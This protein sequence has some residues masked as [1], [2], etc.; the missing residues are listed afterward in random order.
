VL[1]L[2]H[3]LAGASRAE[4][5]DLLRGQA[6]PRPPP[7]LAGAP[8]RSA[9]LGLRRE[10]IPGATFLAAHGHS[11]PAAELA[12]MLRALEAGGQATPPSLPISR[13]RAGRRA[14]RRSARIT[15]GAVPCSTVARG[16]APRGITLIFPRR[17]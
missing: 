3:V 10:A 7:D 12:A 14:A 6:R 4:T 13:A 15:R 16:S 11:D 1:V 8:P 17:S 9:Q 5:S 2:A